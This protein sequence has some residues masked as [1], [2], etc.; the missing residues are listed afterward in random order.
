MQGQTGDESSYATGGASGVSPVKRLQ[1]LKANAKNSVTK[2]V[3]NPFGKAKG[4]LGAKEGGEEN[5]E[6]EDESK[7]ALRN[8]V[9]P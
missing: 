2:S 1:D 3:E 6:G 4:A 5:E 9:S 8:Y 7:V